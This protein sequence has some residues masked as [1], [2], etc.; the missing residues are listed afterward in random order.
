MIDAVNLPVMSNMTVVGF[1]CV[2]IANGEHFT[3]W[4]FT[5]ADRVMSNWIE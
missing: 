4:Y 1:P 3:E 5:A 2:A